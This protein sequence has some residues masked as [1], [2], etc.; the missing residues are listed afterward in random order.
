MWHISSLTMIRRAGFSCC[1][2][3]ARMFILLDVVVTSLSCRS[4]IPGYT[5]KEFVLCYFLHTSANV[6]AVNGGQG[7]LGRLATSKVRS[8][9]GSWGGGGLVF[10]DV[11]GIGTWYAP[12]C[13]HLIASSSS[14]VEAGMSGC[15]VG[16]SSC[17]YAAR[18]CRLSMDF[19]SSS[20]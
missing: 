3:K 11:S 1:V 9:V 10:G 2:K 15:R 16:A 18:P 5:A 14:S 20:V 19:R 13:S 4:K 6:E 17:L 7:L 8:L 12:T